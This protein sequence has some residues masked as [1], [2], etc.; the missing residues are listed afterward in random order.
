MRERFS[1]AIFRVAFHARIW[2]AVRTDRVRLLHISLRTTYSIRHYSRYY[3]CV[4]SGWETN[5]IFKSWIVA[6]RDQMIVAVTQDASFSCYEEK[7]LRSEPLCISGR[8]VGGTSIHHNGSCDK[9]YKVCQDTFCVPKSTHRLIPPSIASSES[10]SISSGVSLHR[11]RSNSLAIKT[12]CS[13]SYIDKS[14]L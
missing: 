1:N 10:S 2:N 3:G 9:G 12:L 4:C 14:H 13:A 7:Y 11:W 5:K 6:L 8:P